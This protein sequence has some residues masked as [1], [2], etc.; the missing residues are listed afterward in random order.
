MLSNRSQQSYSGQL[1]LRQQQHQQQERQAQGR[2]AGQPGSPLLGPAGGPTATS[3]RL[4]TDRSSYI[5]YLESQLERVSAACL[6]VASYDERLEAVTS[7]VRLLE[8]RTLNVT[9]LVSCTQQYAEQQEQAQREGVAALA[10]RL[11]AQEGRLEELTGSQRA[12]E[13]KLEGVGR[14]VEARLKVCRPS[15]FGFSRG[16]RR[17]R[18]E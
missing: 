12:L 8:D 9:R 4:L 11:A 17:R 15:L 10:R 13:D 3:D 18:G 1:L 6:S 14:V 2:A 16:T 5:T 7:A